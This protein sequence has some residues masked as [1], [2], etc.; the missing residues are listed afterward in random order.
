MIGRQA[1]VMVLV[2]AILCSCIT[3]P[4]ITVRTP[5][6]TTTTSVD[7]DTTIAIAQLAFQLAQQG[8]ELWQQYQAGNTQRD[9]VAYQAELLKRQLSLQSRKE[10]LAELYKIKAGEPVSMAPE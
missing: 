9:E 4:T 10:A 1:L 8:L 2:C 3:L 6:G 5:E 7:L